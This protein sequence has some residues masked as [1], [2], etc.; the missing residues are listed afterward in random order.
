MRFNK[1]ESIVIS[2][3]L[4][5]ALCSLITSVLAEESQAAKELQFSRTDNPYYYPSLNDPSNF[6]TWRSEFCNQTEGMDFL[7]QIPPDACSPSPVTSDLLEEQNVPVLCKLTGIKIN[8]LISVPN[9]KRVV[10]IVENQSK[11]IAYI[12]F[13]PARSAL[14]NYNFNDQFQVSQGSPTMSNLG[15]L[16]LFLK[17]QPVEK[18]MPKNVS[19]K[20]AVNI[21]YDVAKTYGI[22]TEQFLLP[23]LTPQ[24]WSNSHT[25]YGFWHGKGYL[26]LQEIKD[27]NAKIAVY[28]KPGASPISILDLRE[29]KSGQVNLPGYYC[30]GPV[31]ISLE[32]IKIPSDSARFII[33]G[34]SY[35]LS[36]RDE[37]ADS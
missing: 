28:T 23:I 29:G 21:T 10:P 25:K 26:R 30:D 27:Q 7:V 16:L 17:Q 36:E 31:N 19:A 6:L 37:F 3:V 4:I 20:I 8:P 12:S 24:E 32:E 9:I 33:N 13:Y 15:Y 35:I 22:S 34:N 1:K 18:N 14:G 11:E 2:L 5:L